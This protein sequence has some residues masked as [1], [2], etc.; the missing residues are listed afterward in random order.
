MGDYIVKVAPERDAYLAISTYSDQVIAFGDRES[1]IEDLFE[2]DDRKRD[3]IRES[4]FGHP[5]NRLVRADER[6]SSSLMG[7]GRWDDESLMYCTH[8]GEHGQQ[9][10]ARKHLG[11]VYD[12]YV[13]AF[14]EAGWTFTHPDIQDLLTDIEDD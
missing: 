3:R 8:D 11:E 10:L 6:G 1:I 14:A 13:T 12:R 2:M 5:E 9:L 4:D 7:D